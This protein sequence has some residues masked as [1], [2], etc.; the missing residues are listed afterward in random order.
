M[1]KS[2]LRSGAV[3]LCAATLAACGGGSGGG[4]IPLTVAVSGMTTGTLKLTNNGGDELS[5][6]NVYS[7]NFSQLMAE[8]REYNVAV[9]QQP[10]SAKCDVVNPKGKISWY[11]HTV[12]VSCQVYMRSLGGTVTGL[13]G[14]GLVLAN[15]S[16]IVSIAPGASTFVFGDKVPH[17]VRYTVGVLKQPAGQTCT[18][19]AATAAGTA[20]STDI[21]NLIVN[22]Q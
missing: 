17:G 16:A 4:N 5:I 12:N 7:S 13:T 2:Y 3:L 1:K 18:V 8:D 11:S 20:G 15:G 9:S 22:C 14:T 19:D 6:A 21:T 10:E